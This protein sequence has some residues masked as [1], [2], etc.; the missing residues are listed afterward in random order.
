MDGDVPMMNRNV[1][2]KSNLLMKIKQNQCGEV[3]TG[4][5]YRFIYTAF[6]GNNKKPNFRF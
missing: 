6:L 1:P 3:F 2:T 4:T 5:M